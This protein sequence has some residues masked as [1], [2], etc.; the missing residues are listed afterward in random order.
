MVQATVVHDMVKPLSSQR[1]RSVP[2]VETSTVVAVSKAM[3]PAHTHHTHSCV[4]EE[5]PM[6]H[7][8]THS[9]PTCSGAKV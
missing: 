5:R 2:P 6:T 1:P 3:P 9:A 8:H 4:S 7:A